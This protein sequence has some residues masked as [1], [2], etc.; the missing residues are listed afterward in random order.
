MQ[1]STQLLEKINAGA[2]P[3]S[4][5]A[6]MFDFDGTLMNTIDIIVESY[7]KTYRHFNLPEPSVEEI[8][9][10]I[11]RPL[12]AIFAQSSK[13]LLPELMQFYLNY[14]LQ[15]TATHCGIFLGIIPMLKE[16]K[17]KGIPLGLVT[18]KRY[19]N[20]I[21]TLEFFE[22]KDFFSAIV[23]K[24]DTEKHKPDPE[25]LL[26]GRERLGLT[27]NEHVMYVGDAIYDIQAAHNGGFIS[28][29]VDWCSIPKATLSAENPTIWLDKATHLPQI[30]KLK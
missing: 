14:N 24:Y 27:N 10:G 9:F 16:L 2:S 6:V 7:Q 30:V 5:E 1:H 15:R 18:A 26:L 20:A 13:E 23:T 29:A 21:D 22:L 3:V 25:P 4:V 28:V 17:N 19:E 8:K 11:G 12:E